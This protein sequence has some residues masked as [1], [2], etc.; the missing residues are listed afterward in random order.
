MKSQNSWN[1][2]YTY[3]E[4]KPKIKKLVEFFMSYFKIFPNYVVIECLSQSEK[5]GNSGHIIIDFGL[6]K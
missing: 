2:F 6:F 4:L 5:Y 3:E 1:K